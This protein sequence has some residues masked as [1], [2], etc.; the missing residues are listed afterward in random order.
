M[1]D[2]NNSIETKSTA[3]RNDVYK[4]LRTALSSQSPIVVPRIDRNV[5]LFDPILNPLETFYENF[6]RKG[7]KCVVI[8]VDRSRMPDRQYAISK[9][10]DIYGY[11]KTEVSQGRYNTVLNAS[12]K[13]ARVLES[14]Q[15][16]FVSALPVG[17][18]ADAAIIYAEY[19]VARTGSIVFSQ[20]EELM[21]Y[22]S[23]RNLARNLIVLAGN[24]CLVPDL[25]DVLRAATQRIQEDNRPDAVELQA[26]TLEILC[27]TGVSKEEATPAEPH[28][29]LVLL[30]ER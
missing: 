15:I 30:V 5:P 24:N 12:P 20:R 16:P 21:L 13:L 19:L 1:P 6:T 7:G 4:A 9:L 17:Q 26:D 18:P 27:P 3:C 14:Y 10:N 29:T 22:P 28:V 11:V 2:Q 23:A 8:E 25:K